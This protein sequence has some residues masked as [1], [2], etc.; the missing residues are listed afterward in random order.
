MPRYPSS[1]GAKRR[2][3]AIQTILDRF[4]SLAV[5]AS[6]FRTTLAR[7]R[8][9][10]PFPFP[11]GPSPTRQSGFALLLVLWTLVLLSLVVTHVIAAGRGEARIAAN[12]GAAAAA[13]AR[14][15][16]AVY[17]TLFRLADSSDAHW[18]ADGDPRVLSFKDA[19]A[20]IR[21]L[22]L[23]GKVNPNL[24]SEPLLAALF[25]VVGADP[26]KASDLAQSIAGWRGRDSW[27]SPLAMRLAPY[28][29][30]GLDDGPPGSPIESLDELGHVLG[31]TPELLKAVLPHLSLYQRGP[32]DP[33]TADPTVARALR[34]LPPA[35]PPAPDDGARRPGLTVSI[36][37]EVNTVGGARFTRHAVARIDPVFARGYAVL[38]WGGE[39]DDGQ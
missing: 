24:A 32:P 18:T 20:V 33:A 5:T 19:R 35:P 29:T 28:R 4:A 13:E 16:G 39:L 30:A 31:M 2:D 15:D 12:L 22:P 1:R 21:V 38:A 6:S 36:E 27:F 8:W 37:V 14:A 34:H 7:P 11:S 3:A 25:A 10:R 23:T 17:E 26:D 9:S